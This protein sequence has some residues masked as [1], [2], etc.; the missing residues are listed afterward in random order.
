MGPTTRIGAWLNKASIDR[1]GAR[2]GL[3]FDSQTLRNEIEALA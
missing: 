2:Q 3:K 1:I